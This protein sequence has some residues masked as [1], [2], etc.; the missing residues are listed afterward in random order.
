MK[1]LKRPGRGRKAEKGVSASVF[2]I[3]LSLSTL[4]SPLL[5][6]PCHLSRRQKCE[7]VKSKP[8]EVHFFRDAKC[9]K[10]KRKTKSEHK[11]QF[12]MN[13]QDSQVS[14]Q[15]ALETI[16]RTNQPTHI[17]KQTEL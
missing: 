1:W 17:K 4:P 13:H 6:F 11:V 14:G 15:L 7:R 2:V 16:R 10:E 9:K 8:A 3:T 5:N 12:K